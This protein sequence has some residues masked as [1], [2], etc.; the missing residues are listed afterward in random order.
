MNMGN[1][2]GNNEEDSDS[3][4]QKQ[5]QSNK[6]KV[7]LKQDQNSS[8]QIMCKIL[9]E[10]E[11]LAI[12]LGYKGKI[13]FGFYSTKSKD[14]K[15]IIDQILLQMT[16]FA[17]SYK[18]FVK[19]NP[20]KQY[21]YP[22][23]LK[24][25][26]IKKIIDDWKKS[27]NKI[28][29][30]DKKLYLTYYDEFL[31]ILS[32]NDLSKNFNDE[33]EKLDQNSKKTTNS[34]LKRVMNAGVLGACYTNEKNNEIEEQINEKGDY[35][36]NVVL[37]GKQED[38]KFNKN[39]EKYDEHF[40]KLKTQLYEILD[41]LMGNLE[42]YALLKAKKKNDLNVK[43]ANNLKNKNLEKTILSN[44]SK[45]LEKYNNI[46]N[47]LFQEFSFSIIGEE[48]EK[49]NKIKEDL[50][51][52]KNNVNDEEKILEFDEAIKCICEEMEPMN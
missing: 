21:E 45:A 42:I 38:N 14:K 26:E 41:L 40:N 5:I 27:I 2:N 44:F 25:E 36:V 32:D 39:M 19:K 20:N 1:Y 12:D 49:I 3:G 17:S 52:W 50:E 10:L 37:N 11:S 9:S 33:F 47:K 18:T 51:K 24:L 34:E 46:N 35:E 15:G 29:D 13:I 8:N 7:I 28:K 43:Y 30:K 4:S 48:K 31:N 16:I 6:Q 23:N 22:K